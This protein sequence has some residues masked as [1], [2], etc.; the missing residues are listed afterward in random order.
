M[1]KGGVGGKGRGGAEWVGKGRADGAAPKIQRT[2]G[3]HLPLGACLFI[4]VEGAPGPEGYW[5]GRLSA[6]ARCRVLRKIPD[7]LES[8]VDKAA[9][10]LND[11]NQGV[12][13]A[14]A[15]ALC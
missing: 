9:D 7:M 13:L 2:E 1:G 14:G 6:P 5:S 15:R 10:L 12:V 8:F 11:R 3:W 4:E